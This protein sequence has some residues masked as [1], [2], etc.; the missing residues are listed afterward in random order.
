MACLPP[1]RIVFGA[2]PRSAIH[3]RSSALAIT[4]RWSNLCPL[5]WARTVSLDM[6]P[7]RPAPICL[8]RPQRRSGICESL[9]RRERDG[10][11]RQGEGSIGKSV[12]VTS[13]TGLRPPSPSAQLSKLSRTPLGCD[14]QKIQNHGCRCAPP[15]APL[16][17]FS[18][19]GCTFG[20]TTALS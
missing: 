6:R 4:T 20:Q 11:K 12:G 9:S 13:L 3:F 10:A 16:K 17:T 18:R 8:R 5:S 7:F 15:V 2:Y 1:R 14:V 19:P